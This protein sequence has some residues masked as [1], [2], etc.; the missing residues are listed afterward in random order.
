ML[1]GL[2]DGHRR[3]R[4]RIQKHVGVRTCDT[5]T[6]DKQDVSVGHDLPRS[7][8][9]N[10]SYY[11][12]IGRSSAR[13]LIHLAVPARRPRFPCRRES[14][15]VC[16]APYCCSPRVGKR[17]HPE[18]EQRGPNCRYRFAAIRGRCRNRST[19]SSRHRAAGLLRVAIDVVRQ[20][21][22]VGEFRPDFLEARVIIRVWSGR[23]TK[24][25]WPD[26]KCKFAGP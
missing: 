9:H 25:S 14:P 22:A 6:R 24:C 20:D 10:W 15:R 21:A 3:P 23:L 12:R 19:S 5:V 8:I 18:A 11:F 13:R 26:C 1:K 7:K 16:R 17:A 2:E 4:D